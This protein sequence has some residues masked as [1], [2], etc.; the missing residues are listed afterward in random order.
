MGLS[1]Q[2]AR[3]LFHL[4]SFGLPQGKDILEFGEAEVI[5]EGKKGVN[6]LSAVMALDA[7][8]AVIIEAR[9]INNSYDT[10]SRY[11]QA[12]IL[13]K[14]F[15]S[16]R[17]YTSI[18]MVAGSEAHIIQDFNQP[19]DLGRRFGVSINNGTSEHVFNQANFFKA[20]HDHTEP[21]G[22]MIHWTPCTGWLDHGLFNAQPS[23][24]H[25]LAAANEYQIIVTGLSTVDTLHTYEPRQFDHT[26][27]VPPQ[28]E[29]SL[30]C[31]CLRKTR[32]HPFKMPIQQC[33]A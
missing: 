15:F 1:I 31:A 17:S 11:R 12:K 22:V 13:Y 30:L 21:D 7:P 20:V 33:P 29:N 8:E 19:F 16:Y 9:G 18:D 28:I 24:I 25:D 32:D 2:E 26:A 5:R 14:A 3:F 10:A 27:R 23:L 4:R 6:P